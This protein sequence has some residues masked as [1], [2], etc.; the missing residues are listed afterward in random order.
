MFQYVVTT[1]T[2]TTKNVIGAGVCF[3]MNI[4]VI[5]ICSIDNFVR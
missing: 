5:N 1:V 2:K 3:F 4:E